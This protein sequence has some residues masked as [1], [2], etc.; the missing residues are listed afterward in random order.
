MEVYIVHTGYEEFKLAPSL[1]EAIAIRR[2]NY[3]N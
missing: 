3:D 1:K 2:E